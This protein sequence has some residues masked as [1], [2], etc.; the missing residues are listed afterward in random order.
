MAWIELVSLLALIQFL[1]FGVLV[2]R[3]RG[4]YGVKAPATTGHEVFERTYRV[5]MNTLETLVIFLPAL[6]LAARYWSPA[7]VG[8][9]G[10][11][12]LLGRVLYA[13]SYIK[14]PASRSMGYLLSMLPTLALLLAALGG[15][16]RAHLIS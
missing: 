6:W 4:L 3:A 10:A 14:D 12:Y 1:V 16:I 5:Q 15:L 11:V 13:R 8:A 7:W 9:V 2:G